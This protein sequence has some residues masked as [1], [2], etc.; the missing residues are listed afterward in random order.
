MQGATTH[1]VAVASVL[2]CHMAAAPPPQNGTVH[3][4]DLRAQFSA[5]HLR[6]MNR[7]VERLADNINGL[8]LSEAEG[9]G[10]AWMDGS[11]FLN[12]SIEVDVRGRD[13]FQ[14]S[15]VGI[16]FHAKDEH[17]YEAVYL[18]PFNFRAAEATRA[19]HAVQYIAMPDFDW[20]RLRRDFPEEFEAPIPASI[21]PNEWVHLR[22]VVENRTVQVYAG[23]ARSPTLQVRRLGKADHGIIGLWVGNNS[24]GEFANVQFTPSQ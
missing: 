23:N 16:A 5:G 21:A 15:F 12:G 8:R 22:V 14:R 18:R 7:N 17:E 4:L 13:V 11:D 19:R 20:P 6:M 1:A 9:P 10:I 3:L 24:D 2:L